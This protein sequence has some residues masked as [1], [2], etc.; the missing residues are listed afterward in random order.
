MEN[1]RE[2]ADQFL[3][4]HAGVQVANGEQL[5]KVWVQLIEDN[6]MRE[7]MG[8]AAREITERN[9]GAT[10]RSLKRIMEVI[11][12]SELRSPGAAANGGNAAEG[13]EKGSAA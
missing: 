10:T 13:N 7:R 2:M 3:D 8:K 4:A 1:F 9:R 6:A 11:A 12:Q 5:G